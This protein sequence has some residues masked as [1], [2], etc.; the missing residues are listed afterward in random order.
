MAQRCQTSDVGTVKTQ[1]RDEMFWDAQPAEKMDQW[2]CVQLIHNQCDCEWWAR[3]VNKQIRFKRT[4]NHFAVT[5]RKLNT[6]RITFWR[7][8]LTE[9]V[10]I[11]WNSV[12]TVN[13]ALYLLAA[14]VWLTGWYSLKKHDHY[15][16]TSADICYVV[17]LAGDTHKSALQLLISSSGPFAML[18][19]FLHWYTALWYTVCSCQVHQVSS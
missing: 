13:R 14:I 7:P 19:V 12:L 4:A 1:R 15:A 10:Y 6:A 2:D 5:R 18:S 9:H 3:Q 16:F 11:W 17:V 8:C